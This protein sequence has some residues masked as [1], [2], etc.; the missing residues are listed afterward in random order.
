MIEHA[1]QIGPGRHLLG[2]W[3]PPVAARQRLGVLM[4]NAG[5]IHRIGA[6]RIHVKLAR[7]L[8]AKG[9]GCARFDFSGVGD[10]R[11]PPDAVDFRAQAVRDVR[12]VM[13]AIQRDQGIDRFALVGICSGAANAQAAALADERVRGVFLIDGYVYPTRKGHAHFARRM[14]QAY[15]AGGFASRL[16]RFAQGRLQAPREAVAVPADEGPTRSRQEFDADMTALSVRG[17]HVALLFTGSYLEHFG[18]A[19]QLH[20]SFA[21]ATWL[22]HVEVLFE[23]D[24]DHTITLQ[25]SQRRLIELVD[26]WTQRVA[27]QRL[28]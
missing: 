22:D 10:S 27:G 1:F 26:P 8:A 9:F 16:A 21:G 28:P 20:D 18:Y 2:I 23:P 5:V 11:P 24:L 6:H 3:T 19:R 12:C 14:L 7:H 25:A 4:L 15:G 17:V 13:D